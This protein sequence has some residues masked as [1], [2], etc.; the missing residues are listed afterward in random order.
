[1]KVLLIEE[2]ARSARTLR[3][4]LEAM[5]H[6]VVAAF[7]ESNVARLI[8]VGETRLIICRGAMAGWDGL[9]FC[10]QLRRG[11]SVPYLYTIL[12]I[13]NAASQDVL[14]ALEAGADDCL[15][16][17]LDTR[18]LEARVNI[19]TRILS[20]QRM[21]ETR[22]RRVHERRQALARKIARLAEAASSD[23]LTRL[24]NHR[25]FLEALDRGV[26]FARRHMLSLSI[27]MLDIDQFKLYNDVHGH[28]AGDEALTGMARILCDNTREHDL[29]ARYGGDEFVLLLTG[30]DADAARSF[31]E[32]I[33]ARVADHPWPFG[34]VTASLG[35]ATLSATTGHPGQL[36]EEAD[37]A[38]Y[39]SKAMGRDR[40]S[41]FDEIGQVRV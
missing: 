22:V 7:G 28:P 17:P 15:S 29:A 12:L 5:G 19:A 33:R 41:H 8:E 18:E 34:P 9:A 2:D 20:S 6:E 1:M 13:E 35:I 32:R 14:D 16:T 37:R 24:K 21:L 25:Y 11:A 26:S 4:T 30:A 10:R 38:L 31:C 3:A 27:V 36:L 23:S 39:L 40:I